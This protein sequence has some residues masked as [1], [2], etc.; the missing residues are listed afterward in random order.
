L[1]IKDRPVGSDVLSAGLGVVGR[2]LGVQLEWE[3]D[4]GLHPKVEL[5]VSQ[6]FD[7]EQIDGPRPLSD[8]AGAAVTLRG[9][10][11]PTT[12][13]KVGA[14]AQNRYADDG[15]M[16]DRYWAGGV[17]LEAEVAGLRLWADGIAGTSHLGISA[18]AA[19]F[20]VAQ[21]VAGWRQGGHKQGKR[22]VEPF[23]SAGYVDPNLDAE[24]DQVTQLK[25]GVAGGRWKRWRAQVQ[26]QLQQVGDTP[27]AHLGGLN[28]SPGDWTAVTA[29]LGAAF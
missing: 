1:A 28:V 21:A 2:Q 22:Y 15:V 27:T 17:D 4:A 11:E 29:Q 3:Y 20:V 19:T 9:E 26:L 8:Y 12:D 18:D 13:V 24:D 7:L 25:A 14:F 6:P 23:V 16:A 5:A 10:L